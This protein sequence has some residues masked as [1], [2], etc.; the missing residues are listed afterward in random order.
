VC[1]SK[2]EKTSECPSGSYDYIDIVSNSSRF[3][4]E[5]SLATHFEIA[6]PTDS[7]ISLLQ[8]FPQIFVG[9]VQEIKKIESMNKGGML[10]IP[11][12]RRFAYMQA[13]WVGPY[14]RTIIISEVPN[15]SKALDGDLAIMKSIGFVVV[16]SPISYCL[17]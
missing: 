13:K 3:I 7:Y 9:E 10:S 11:P 12:W 17:R 6:K 15:A 1:N 16:K 5:V 2:C 14:K 8:L 4:I